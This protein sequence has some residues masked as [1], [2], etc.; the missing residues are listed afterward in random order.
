MPRSKIRT[1]MSV[2]A[3]V[4]ALATVVVLTGVSGAAPMTASYT[5][6][7]SWVTGHQASLTV[8]NPTAVT[9]RNWVLTFDL[10]PKISSLWGGTLSSQVAQKVTVKAP[11]WAPD[12]LS[13]GSIT[14]G[15]VAAGP[16]EAPTNC[17]LNGIT[18]G[19]PGATTTPTTVPQTTVPPTTTTT[20]VRPTTTTIP[21]TT[22]TTTIRPTTT[23]VPPTT[24][25]P[26][27]VPAAGS[28]TLTMAIT[29]DW[30]T[31]YNADITITNPGPTT[32]TSWS[33][34]FTSPLTVSSIWNGIYQSTASGHQVSNETWNGSVAPGASVTFGITG[35]GDSRQAT[36]STCRVNNNNCT[37]G[38]T[39]TIPE[40]PTTTVPGSPTTTVPTTTVPTTPTTL[41]TLP[42]GATNVPYSPY[43]DAT[44]WPTPDLVQTAAARS[45]RELTLAFIVSGSTPCRASWGG[46][47]DRDA[48]FM[49]AQIA[50]LRAAGGDVIMSFGGAANQELALTCTTVQALADEYQAVIDAYQ[51]TSIDFDIEGAA[52][53]DAASVQRRS[54]AIAILQQRAKAANR[55]LD[56][57]LT[58]PVMPYGLTADGL[59]V[60]RSAVNAG[61]VL[62]SIDLMTM[63]YGLGSA[64]GKMGIWAVE[65]ATATHNQIA[66]L[67]PTLSSAQRY[68]LVGVIPMIGQNDILGEVFTLSD[69]AYV[70]SQATTLGFARIGIWSASRDQPCPEGPN[71]RAQNNCS[72][73]AAAEGAFSKALAGA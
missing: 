58:L 46:Y 34:T 1:R 43:V 37:V 53:N 10:A 29:S 27:T 72:S 17:K 55:K 57:T 68:G 8:G 35:V 44:N 25:P 16:G 13:G 18:C 49:T 6:E 39:V 61:V 59:A 67:Y 30:V 51:I 11:T 62:S 5:R 14:I 31:G 71:T 73:V 50:A 19:L 60:V 26:T 23:T 12:L 66:P 32:W 56:V 4:T 52:T 69:A 21:A 48:K 47:Y 9:Q 36:P 24:V 42:T 54:A 45:T 15:Y 7:N 20:T 38:S 63:D 22:T 33:A 64:E 2:L 41:P 65:A 70:R 28:A 3:T 40:T